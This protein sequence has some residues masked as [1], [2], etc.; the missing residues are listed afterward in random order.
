MEKHALL[1]RRV[2]SFQV[3]VVVSHIQETVVVLDLVRSSFFIVERRL[4]MWAARSLR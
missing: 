4:V 3:V 1:T 2:E